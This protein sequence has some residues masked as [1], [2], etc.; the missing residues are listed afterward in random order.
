[1]CWGLGERRT[2]ERNKA[3]KC[4]LYGKEHA[5]TWAQ[6]R[7]NNG[8]RTERESEWNKEGKRDYT[9]PGKETYCS[10]DQGVPDA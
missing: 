6:T 8:G 1:M 2:E 3:E 9:D 4:T 7:E 5:N 10:N